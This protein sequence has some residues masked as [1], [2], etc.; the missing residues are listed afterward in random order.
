MNSF[1]LGLILN[2]TD[3]ATSGM[4]VAIGTF[5]RMNAT[6]QAMT[7]AVDE[8]V[9]AFNG[10]QM[11][12]VGVTV[13]G[14]TVENV[15][16]G[17]IDIFLRI[18][19]QV[20]T[21]GSDFEKSRI[22]LET[23]Y[24]DVDVAQQK[25]E[26][27]FTYARDTPF[28]I[29]TLK[30]AQTALK[31]MGLEADKV[32]P[33]LDGAGQSLMSFIGDLGAFRPD[34]PLERIMQGIRNTIGGNV[35]SLDMILDVDVSS[36]I[37]HELT[38]VEE[39]LPKLVEALG[40]EGLMKNLEGTW[41]VTVSGIKDTWTMLLYYIGQGGIY[42]EAEDTINSFFNIIKDIPLEEYQAVG[43]VISDAFSEIIKPV[44]DLAP[45]LG[46]AIVELKDWI[47]ENPELAKSVIKVTAAVGGVLFLTGA[48]LKLAGPM[49]IA[50]GVFGMF[51][52]TMGGVSATMG[53]L[54]TSLLSFGK[55]FSK[56]FIGMFLLFEAYQNNILG[57]R[58]LINNVLFPVLS[59]IA[60]MIEIIFSNNN[61]SADKLKEANDKGLI[62]FINS[63]RDLGAELSKLWGA[64][65]DWILTL[66]VGGFLVTKIVAVGKAI[67]SVFEFMEILALNLPILSAGLAGLYG[68]CDLALA[69]LIGV[70]GALAPLIALAVAGIVITVVFNVVRKE[71]DDELQQLA[72]G[73]GI[74]GNNPT[75]PTPVKGESTSGAGWY[76]Q[77]EK[78]KQDVFKEEKA[79]IEEKIKTDTYWWDKVKERFKLWKLDFDAGWAE[80]RTFSAQDIRW[81]MFDEWNKFLNG[82][83]NVD[84][85]KIDAFK[86]NVGD[87]NET[88]A[89]LNSTNEAVSGTMAALGG[90]LQ[91]GWESF[92]GTLGH[93]SEMWNNFINDHPMLAKFLGYGNSEMATAQT[94]LDFSSATPD[95]GFSSFGQT[96]DDLSVV[97]GAK[98][99]GIETQASDAGNNI[100]TNLL[101]NTQDL[102]MSMQNRGADTMSGFAI[103]VNETDTAALANDKATAFHRAF[104]S[105]LGIQSPSK[106]MKEIG[107]N[108]IQGLLNGLS[109]SDMLQFVDNTVSQIKEAFANGNFNI[110]AAVEFLGTGA[111]D[112][113]K[114]I[115]VGGASLGG[116]VQPVSG[117]ITS[118]FGY[119]DDVQGVGTSDHAGL[120]I[121]A[122]E[123]TP[124][125]AAG[126]GE[127]VQAGWNGG[128]GNSV[129]LDHGAGLQTL[130][131]HLSSVL[132]TVGQLVQ[133]MQ[134]IGLVG[135][136]GN[137][138]GP[139]LHFGVMKDGNWVDPSSIYGFAR[140][141]TNFGGGMARVY[142][143][144][145]EIITLPSG[146]EILPNDDTVSVSK[147]AGRASAYK[148]M[149]SNT[150]KK[151]ENG[152]ASK[153][154]NRLIFSEGSVNIQ[155]NG[156]SDTDV[157]D[158]VKRI[159]NEV[160]RQDE[161]RR[162]N[163][164]SP[165][166]GN[167]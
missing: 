77:Q 31:A 103:G 34:L 155:M 79:A 100:T 66:L 116:L 95:T 138:T 163:V 71:L 62:P 16:K 46:N 114:S 73:K 134:T 127:V 153:V 109:G 137:S 131:G 113:L 59:D 104:K 85:D 80:D 56:S 30:T 166:F 148:E 32:L 7:N 5:Q 151:S 17:I 90:A 146:T 159:M 69:G 124:V 64:N 49:M 132:V 162:M 1:G 72:E 26:W 99:A 87:Y 86:K 143:E 150:L 45:V 115:G 39:D 28:E 83:N 119:R 139:H 129:I 122:S 96:L 75:E 20:I 22:T 156:T 125:G 11:V 21:T 58:D 117:S 167:N 29:G 130:Y 76:E 81:G 105:S 65:K 25:L 52:N 70:S 98:F 82:A 8:S 135:S 13:L 164:R 133:Q 142:E 108:T 55:V 53:I 123:G 157:R 112:W 3:N 14:N 147:D 2:F 47:K 102:P 136:T 93:I 74:Y 126:A 10:L 35:R 78:L 128:Y 152:G 158:T 89:S 111:N 12:G 140:G 44:K 54:G 68:S 145:G 41:S 121:G 97:T 43:K 107:K 101:T 50:I 88:M 67:F 92:M 6:A 4:N 18:S 141:T 24:K 63:V 94:S 165:I 61:V 27:L 37:G 160:K 36:L 38:N 161:I 23:M 60:L 106:V 91:A 19:E 42:K 149:L 144:G 33:T 118:N 120:D 57:F 9:Q 40:A 110:K 154:D 48:V 51:I 84:Q 15:G